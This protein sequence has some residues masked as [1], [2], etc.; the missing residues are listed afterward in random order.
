MYLCVFIFSFQDAANA[1]CKRGDLKI[2]DRALRVCHAA[3]ADATPSKRKDSAPPRRDFP[4]KK[5]AVSSDE[6]LSGKNGKPKPS[7]ASLS[8]QGLRSSKS[9]AVKK[10][11]LR[12]RPNS[13]Q[14]NQATRRAGADDKQVRK[15]KR[16]AV[17]ARKAKL[18]KKRKQ[19]NE[20]PE[21]THRNKRVRRQ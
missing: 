20:T 17:A 3:R 2:R 14:G 8:Y 13:G 21:N 12:L 6:G 5:F 15:A 9:G 1:V 19:E 18:L 4:R 11:G 10:S 16:P 7:A